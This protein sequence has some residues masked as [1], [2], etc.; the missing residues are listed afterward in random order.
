MLCYYGGYDTHPKL[1]SS[2]DQQAHETHEQNV[3][4]NTKAFC[5]WE[6]R[7]VEGRIISLLLIP[8]HRGSPSLPTPLPSP[9]ASSSLSSSHSRAASTHAPSTLPF[10]RL[11]FAHL[12]FLSLPPL[13]SFFFFLSHICAAL[14]DTNKVL[15]QICTPKPDPASFHA[16]IIIFPS[17]NMLPTRRGEFCTRAS[18]QSATRSA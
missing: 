2:Q 5:C 6:E 4:H 16:L 17:F 12:V 8:G 11:Y 14:P 13:L 18:P 9:M 7:T 15:L 10:A 1:R 3:Y